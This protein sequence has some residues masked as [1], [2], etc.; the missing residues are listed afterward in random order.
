MKTIKFK[1]VFMAIM[2]IM[3]SVSFVSCSDDEEYESYVV[4][5]W[6]AEDPNYSAL[7]SYECS[8]NYTFRANG[9]GYVVWKKDGTIIEE[10][11]Y[12]IINLNR[13][14]GSNIDFIIKN[15]ALDS[16]GN[17]KFTERLGGIKKGKKTWNLTTEYGTVVTFIMHKK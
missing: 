15:T 7:P 3:F 2:A 11:K 6:D 14:S 16:D 1:T 5:S 17:V 9:T 10:F 12:E 13:E 8:Y 4:G